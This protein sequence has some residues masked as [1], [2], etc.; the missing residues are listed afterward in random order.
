MKNILVVRLSSLGDIV[1]TQPVIESIANKG[2]A[3]DL[4]VHPD[5]ASV[6]KML[7]GVK[8][9]ITAV[10]DAKPKYDLILDLHGTLRAR[11]VI[12][13]ISAKCVIHYNKK[14]MAR[15]LL[16]SCKG[17]PRVWNAFSNLSE[18]E[19]VTDWYAQA[20]LKAGYG[21]LKSWPRLEFSE[22][23]KTAVQQIMDKAKI[24][25]SERYAV[26]APGAKWATKQW[27]L[28][29]FIQTAEQLWQDMGLIPVFVGTGRERET[30]EKAAQSLGHRALSLAG[31]TNLPTLAALLQSAAVLVANDS[32]PLHL[33][34]AA[35]CAVIA[36]FGPTV[37]QFGFAPLTHPKARVLARDMDCRP[38]SVHGSAACPLQHHNCLRRILPAEVAA[39]AKE[40]L[41]SIPKKRSGKKENV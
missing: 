25:P 31:L 9:V 24:K 12:Q 41:G 3:V 38:C 7:P 33:G 14:A 18:E 1:L 29:Y 16:V 23:E 39:A 8:Q 17:R 32:G 26:F 27:P 4:L 21:K 6:G 5:Y 22:W 19:Q 34:L 11:R 40:L 37:S 28:D 2:H 10:V 15:R 13:K 36:L 20:A 30:C 35:G